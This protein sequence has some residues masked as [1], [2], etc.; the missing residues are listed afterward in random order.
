MLQQTIN[1][2]VYDVS[3]LQQY[4]KTG[5]DA[6][7]SDMTRILESLYIHLLK[8]SHGLVLIN[9]NL[10]NPNFPAIDLVDDAR[11]T[12]VQVTSNANARKIRHTLKMF[13][14]HKLVK[15]Y[16]ALMILGF[17]KCSKLDTLPSYC[18]VFSIGQLI[19]EVTDKNDDKLAQDIVDALEQH[20]DFSRIHPYDDRNCLEI[21]LNCIDRNAVKHRMSCEGDYND[22]VKGL[23]E[24]TELISKGSINNR[25]KGKALDDFQDDGIKRVLIAIRDTIGRIVAI[26]NQCRHAESTFVDIPGRQMREIDEMKMKITCLANEVAHEQGLLVRIHMM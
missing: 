18:T 3:L 5:Q 2:L 6:G 14:N 8:V 24:I 21:V 23:N 22:M 7:F 26:V 9:K 10:L 15:D 25:S 13:E 17:V 11:R 16:D 1:N 12:A 19:S 4:I 20:S